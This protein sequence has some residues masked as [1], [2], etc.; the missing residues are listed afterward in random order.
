MELRSTWEHLRTLTNER[1]EESPPVLK[2]S[3]ESLIAALDHAVKSGNGHDLLSV[4]TH[5]PWLRVFRT[6]I[7][8]DEVR[9]IEWNIAEIAWPELAGWFDQQ[10]ENLP[11]EAEM[12]DVAIL[13]AVW[14]AICEAGIDTVPTLW[15]AF[16]QLTEQLALDPNKAAW[17]EVTD[18]VLGDWKELPGALVDKVAAL[19][20]SADEAVLWDKRQADVVAA[21]V[22]AMKETNAGH[23]LDPT[24]ASGLPYRQDSSNRASVF[25]WSSLGALAGGTGV[26]GVVSTLHALRERDDEERMR[27][28]LRL[29]RRRHNSKYGIGQVFYGDRKP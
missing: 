16:E 11:A 1:V 15:Y 29:K 4:G 9:E 12:S 27:E 22:S 25:V 24:P 6:P 20:E 2:A 26:A 28:V 3:L 7:S 10:E 21:T 5:I 8:F 23:R 13:D 19:F 18:E 14:K 17:L